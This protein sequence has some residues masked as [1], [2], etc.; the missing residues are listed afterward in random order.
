MYV[1][2]KWI[3]KDLIHKLGV[4]LYGHQGKG[5]FKSLDFKSTSS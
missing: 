4:F 1:R 5:I 2:D 3:Q